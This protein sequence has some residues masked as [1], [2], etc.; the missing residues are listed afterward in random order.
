[1]TF[2]LDDTSKDVKAHNAAIW[3]VK[4][5]LGLDSILA[6]GWLKKNPDQKCYYFNLIDQNNK[7]DTTSPYP[8]ITINLEDQDSVWLPT[9]TFIIRTWGVYNDTIYEAFDTLILDTIFYG[10]ATNIEST[11][12]PTIKDGPYGIEQGLEK[13]VEEFK[14]WQNPVRDKIKVSGT[15]GKGFSVYDISGRKIK[16]YE[17][18]STGIY[19]FD[20][21]SGIYFVKPDEKGRKVK[22]IIK[23]R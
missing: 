19:N 6:E 23:V 14:I 15:K 13:K 22:K 8:Q 16:S 11:I 17:S 2:F 5:T 3:K 4:D 21:P 18:N 10:A 20:I 9:D 7:I 1:M 12:V